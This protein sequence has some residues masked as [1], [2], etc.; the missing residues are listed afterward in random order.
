MALA[1]GSNCGRVGWVP[2]D[3]LRLVYGQQQ[4]GSE[5]WT[6][7]STYDVRSPGFITWKAGENISICNWD[8]KGNWERNDWTGQSGAGINLATGDFG[9]FDIRGL[10]LEKVD[11]M[12]MDCTA[13]LQGLK[14]YKELGSDSRGSEKA[15]RK[16]KESCSQSQ[17]S[18]L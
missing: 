10:G 8:V 15:E 6:A 9:R 7:L 11:M 16:S 3:V 12:A 4:Y 17:E 14:V 5:I 13:Y 2:A 18:S 1:W